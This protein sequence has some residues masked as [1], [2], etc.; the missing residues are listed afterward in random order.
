MLTGL[1]DISHGRAK[2]YGLDVEQR[3][4]EIRKFMGVCP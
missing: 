1:L 3:V 2:A 4:E